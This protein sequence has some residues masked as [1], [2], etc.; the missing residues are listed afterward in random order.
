MLVHFLLSHGSLRLCSV[1]FNLFPFCSTDTIISIVLPSTLLIPFSA[2]S[3]LLLNPSSEFENFSYCIFQLQHS[4]SFSFEI[5]YFFID[6]SR[7]SCIVFLTFSTSSYSSL[8]IVKTVVSKSLSGIPA[9]TPFSGT[10]SVDLFVPL[11]GPY[12][13]V[14]LWALWIFCCWTLDIWV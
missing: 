10:V 9:I 14:S 8:N 1:F 7:F 12:I 13:L 6:I 2:C 5:F 3:A 11:N 4:F